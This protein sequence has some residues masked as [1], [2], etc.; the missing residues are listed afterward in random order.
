MNDWLVAEHQ[1]RFNQPPDLFTARGF[2]TA[3]AIVAGIKKANSA[4]TEK[5]IAAMENMEFDTPKG[6]MKFR[7]EDHQAMQVQSQF[8]MKKAPKGD[9]DLLDLVREGRAF[10]MPVPIK[11]KS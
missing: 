2:V 4:D 3:A 5:L 8:R 11:V 1:K 10:E 9:W 7:N 6:K